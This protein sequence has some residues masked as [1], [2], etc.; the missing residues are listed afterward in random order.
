VAELKTKKTAASVD[1]FHTRLD[2]AR[3][4]DCLAL[5]RLMQH[6][7][8]SPP[9]MWGTSIVGFGDYNYKYESG[10]GGEWF[11]MGFS[12]RKN[13]LTLYIN[14][15]IGYFREH[16]ARLG[17]HKTGVSC[18]YIKRLADIDVSVLKRLVTDAAKQLKARTQA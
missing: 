1:G 10:R 3:R 17:P 7:T 16:L 4:E 18:L 15:G 9:R 5:V 14:P 13:D 11:V 2:P 12:P 6:A 8:K